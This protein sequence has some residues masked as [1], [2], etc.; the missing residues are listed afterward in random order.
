MDNQ[1]QFTVD[2]FIKKFSEIPEDKFT[3]CGQYVNRQDASKMCALGH[4]NVRTATS[5]TQENFPEAHALD[6]LL[7]GCT[8]HINDGVEGAEKFGATPK[9]RILAAL[10]E[11]KDNGKLNFDIFKKKENENGN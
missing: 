10:Q 4:C 5:Y 9:A 8:P 1:N 3:S 7:N 6:D 2:H 11:V